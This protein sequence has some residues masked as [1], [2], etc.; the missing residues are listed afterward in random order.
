MSRRRWEV[1]SQFWNI[2]HIEGDAIESITDV[3]LHEGDQPKAWV[4]KEDFPED[5][6]K[7]MAKL[8]GLNGS[9]GEGVL[10]Y[11]PPAVINNPTWTLLSLGD[12]PR[13]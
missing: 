13:R 2:I 3:E 5:T 1:H 11:F 9:Q 10:V 12:H 8:H 6:I 7:C 4:G